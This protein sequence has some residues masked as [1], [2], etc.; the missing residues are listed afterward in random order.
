ML[1]PHS[2]NQHTE[3]ILYGTSVSSLATVVILSGY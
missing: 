1:A 2:I 3:K